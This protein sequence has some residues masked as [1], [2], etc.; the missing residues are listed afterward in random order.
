M[1]IKNVI[2]LFIFFSSLNCLG[3]QNENKPNFIIIFVDDMGYGDIG[4]FGNPTIST[5]NLDNMAFEGQ[6]WTQFY[7]A[8]PVCTPSRAALLT[9]RYPIRNG[10]TSTKNRVLFPNSTGGLPKSEFTIAEKL[11]EKKYKTAIVGKWHLGHQKKYLPNNHGFDYYYGIPYSNDMDKINNNNYWSEYERK[12]LNSKSYNVPLIEN[13]DIIERPVDQTTITKR[14]TEKTLDL[15]NDL[16]NDNFF[17]YLSHNLPHIPLYASKDFLGKSKAGIY[18]DVIEEIDHGVG[19]IL[20]ELK[21][22]NIDKKTVVV[23]TSDNGPWLVYKTHSGSAGHLRNG[24]GTTWEGGVRV[25][26]I[27]WGHN[28]KPG[29][30]SDLGSTLDIYTTFLS[31]SNIKPQKNMIIDGYDLTKTLF[32]HVKSPRKE[33]FYYNGGELFAVRLNDFKLHFKTSDWFKQPKIHDPPLLYNLNI[34]P[35]ERLNIADKNPKKI[36]EILELVEKHN[37][38]M[39]IGK[40]QMGKRN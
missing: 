15:I 26:T 35:S 1:F 14:Y 25:P 9:G 2:Y 23:F 27:F 32:E 31:L 17:I 29:V 30:I 16:K 8:A 40:D 22:L 3:F 4:V 24:K 5:P 36:K 39:V 20:N 28:I 11:K 34:D 19:L 10:M 33:M 7:S 38:N 12:E 18:G 37:S 6:K 13:Y 21:K